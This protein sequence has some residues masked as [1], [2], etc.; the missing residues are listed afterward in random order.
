MCPKPVIAAV[1]GVCVTGALE[2]A[3]SCD[4]IVAS[5]RARFADTH[6]KVGFRPAWGMSVFLPRAVGARKAIEMAITGRFL[7]ADEALRCG[8][9]NHVVA[10]DEL[11]PFTYALAADI[12]ALD[13][14]TVRDLLALFRRTPRPDRRRRARLGA[15][16]RRRLDGP[17]VPGRR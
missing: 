14:E 3:L 13:R 6:G 2:L 5:E 16:H 7:E 4:I 17:A 15:G 10:H 9:V 8:L 12:R 1:N 11:M